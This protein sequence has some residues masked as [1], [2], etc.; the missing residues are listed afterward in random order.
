M[1][2]VK[3]QVMNFH[4]GITEKDIVEFVRE[5]EKDAEENPDDQIW[6]FFDEINTCEHLGVIND[7]ICHRSLLGAALPTNLVFMAACNP[8]CLRPTG[9]LLL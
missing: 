5:Q 7:V 3:F 6:V 2:D 1:C 9:I 8:Y 4:A